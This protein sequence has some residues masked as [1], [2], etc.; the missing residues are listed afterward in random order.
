MDWHSSA[1]GDR[2]K[3]ILWPGVDGE[4]KMSNPG[5]PVPMVP[6][7]DRQMG[8][9]AD[10]EELG[11]A[12]WPRGEEMEAAELPVGW[13]RG[14]YMML[15]HE[16]PE[17]LSSGTNRMVHYDPQCAWPRSNAGSG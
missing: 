7:Q 6:L 8:S 10:L 3:Y 14:T 4:N 16:G 11:T 17:G 2:R 15:L 1:V 5:T 13:C 9:R 12:L